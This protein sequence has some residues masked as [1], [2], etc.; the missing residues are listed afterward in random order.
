MT[1]EG[2]MLGRS[3]RAQGFETVSFQNLNDSQ[4]GFLDWVGATQGGHVFDVTNS[5]IQGSMHPL[6]F[7]VP[8]YQLIAFFHITLGD[9]GTPAELI[10]DFRKFLEHFDLNG[11]QVG[12]VW[13]VGHAF[14]NNDDS[15]QPSDLLHIVGGS[16]AGRLAL[17]KPDGTTYDDAIISA[18]GSSVE[19]QMTVNVT[20]D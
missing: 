2:S 8:A 5:A 12:S 10:L 7:N 19:G 11:F 15:E 4:S 14:V 16:G 18:G 1:G 17:L 3:V 13:A 9:D 6:D 20:N